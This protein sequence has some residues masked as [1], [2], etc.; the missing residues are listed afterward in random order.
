MSGKAEYTQTGAFFDTVY[1]ITRKNDNGTV[2]MQMGVNPASALRL[3]LI[4]FVVISLAVAIVKYRAKRKPSAGLDSA[5]DGYVLP[6]MKTENAPVSAD[7]SAD[8]S[9]ADSVFEAGG[10]SDFQRDELIKRRLAERNAKQSAPKQ[11]A[12]QNSQRIS[13]SARF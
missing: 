3:L 1:F 10:L 7:S 2:G 12:A 6:E 8:S 13:V 5:K 4:V 11:N 9:D